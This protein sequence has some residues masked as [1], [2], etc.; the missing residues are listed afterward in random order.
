[1]SLLTRKYPFSV[2]RHR[3]RDS[4]VYGVIIWAILYLLQ[5]FGFSLYT[6]NKFLVAGSFGLITSICYFI[7]DWLV[8]R[9]LYLKVKPWRIW[10]QG[11]IE[12]VLYIRHGKHSHHSAILYRH[13]V[14]TGG[15]Q[16]LLHPVGHA[17][18]RIFQGGSDRTPAIR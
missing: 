4:I 10:H 2:R 7:Y 1:M 9:W 11:H 16:D 18:Q 6:G 3:L 5:P 13:R 15:R 14:P 12:G 17:M 8:L